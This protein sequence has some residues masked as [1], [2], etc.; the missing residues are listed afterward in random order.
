MIS[1]E[2]ADSAL[3][4]PFARIKGAPEGLNLVFLA[5]INTSKEERY[6]GLLAPS[7][8]KI[9]SSP[10]TA[11]II[12]GKKG[13]LRLLVIEQCGCIKNED[14][15]FIHSENGIIA[16]SKN[17]EKYYLS[18]EEFRQIIIPLEIRKKT[19]ETVIA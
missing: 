4:V 11:K 6:C 7:A 18:G 12:F 5:E 14:R 10:E 15:W 16:A 17:E 19:A 1:L 2:F 8:E 3:A 9:F 13:D